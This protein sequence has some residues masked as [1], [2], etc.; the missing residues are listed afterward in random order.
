MRFFDYIQNTFKEQSKLTVLIIL[1]VS[2]FL[3]VNV[4]SN[5]SHLNL[6]SYLALPLNN[7]D[8]IFK[9]WTLFTYMFTHAGLGHVFFNLILLFFSGRFF[10]SLLGEKRLIYL[11]IMSGLAGGALLL[12]LG[13]I[14]PSIFENSIL[15][16]ASA[17]VL[18]IITALAVY[19][20]NMP[21]NVFLLLEMPY[22][23]FALLVFVIS[24][25]IDF[26][27]NTGGKISHIGGALF[28]LLYGYTLK[29]GKNV[30][31]FSF[32][33]QKKSK[34]KIIHQN[35]QTNIRYSESSDE[36]A[37]LNKLLDKISKSG[38]DSLTKN[39]KADLFKLSQK[40]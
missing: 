36:D 12:I 8:F 22:K 38:Y 14:F 11:Y 39:E 28:G 26:A 6:L 19:V 17:A 7:E 23:Y 34:L 16:G 40:K 5:I 21:V 24:T 3:T 32:I 10:Y 25:V 35:K 9:P 18:G 2:V 4:I 37:Y 33:P 27:V 20:P 30:F 13:F 29:S 15:I 1:N 31:N